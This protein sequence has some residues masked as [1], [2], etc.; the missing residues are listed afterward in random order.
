MIHN[1]KDNVPSSLD[2]WT[3]FL[4]EVDRARAAVKCPVGGDTEPW[5]RGHSRSDYGLI[6]SLFRMF[7]HPNKATTWRRIFHKETDLFWEFAA[8]AR[9]LH[10]KLEDDWDILFAMQHYG[11]PTRLLDWTE[12]LAVAVYFATLAID[13]TRSQKPP[14]VWVLNP[15]GLNKRAGWATGGVAD[16]VHPPNLGWDGKEYWTYGDLLSEG[17]MDWDWPTAIYPRHKNPRLQAQQGG[18]T[19]HGD[20]FEPLEKMGQTN[21]FLRKVEIPYAAVA[22]AKRFLDH[23]GLSH[24]SLFSDLE[25]LAIQLQ[26]KNGLITREEAELKIKRQQVRRR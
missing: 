24:Y 19:I 4:E 20:E 2:P 14:C 15:Y 18:F 17:Y 23:A 26:E 13:V 11:V 21:G 8:R 12:S 3:K 25:S 5:F 1:K 9:E 10:G 22:G 6:P 7:D 16:V